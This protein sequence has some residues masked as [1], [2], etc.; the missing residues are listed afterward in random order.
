MELDQQEVVNLLENPALNWTLAS[1]GNGKYHLRQADKH[2]MKTLDFDFNDDL[3][4]KYLNREN[5]LG[6]EL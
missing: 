2:Y 6:I 4:S 1:S 5:V 3:A